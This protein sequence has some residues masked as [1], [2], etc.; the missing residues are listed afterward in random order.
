MK[1]IAKIDDRLHDLITMSD[2]ESVS[3]STVFST[4]RN[5]AIFIK[6]LPNK[7]LRKTQKVI[8]MILSSSRASDSNPILCSLP[9]MILHPLAIQTDCPFLLSLCFS[10]PSIFVRN[11]L[12]YIKT[13]DGS[14]TRHRWIIS[15]CVS[16]SL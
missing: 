10:C 6:F 15:A 11:T 12:F 1:D 4:S 7:N 3:E 5:Y 9:Q 16:F 13:L 2:V 8:P 14:I